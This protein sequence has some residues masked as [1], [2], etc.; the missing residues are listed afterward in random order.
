MSAK[1]TA[2]VQ[3]AFMAFG[4]VDSPRLLRTLLLALS[5]VLV[6]LAIAWLNKRAISYFGF[7]LMLHLAIP[8]AG[9]GR[10]DVHH[11]GQRPRSVDRRL[12]R[13]RRL[14]FRYGLW[15]PVRLTTIGL[16]ASSSLV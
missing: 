13:F 5:L 14:P 2:A 6:L 1:P 12:R 7:T 16:M 9:D 10:A 8:I 15:A 3:P 11:Y 4:K